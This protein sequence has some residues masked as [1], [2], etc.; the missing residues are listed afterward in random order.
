MISNEWLNFKILLAS[1]WR[2]RVEFQ[3]VYSRLR[4]VTLAL[5]SGQNDMIML[6]CKN[7]I[8]SRSTPSLNS[9]LNRL[10]RVGTVNFEMTS[11]KVLPIQIRWPPRNGE[12]LK[13]LRFFPSGLKK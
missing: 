4:C 10:S 3:A 12:K 6:L 1:C 11:M 13:V 5:N 8:F 9:N 7:G 2:V